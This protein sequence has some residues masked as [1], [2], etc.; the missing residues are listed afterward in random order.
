MKA[1]QASH[2][3][4]FPITEAGQQLNML[5]TLLSDVASIGK[6]VD[7]GAVARNCTASGAGLTQASVGQE[8][9][10]VIQAVNHYDMKCNRGGD[11]FEVDALGDPSIKFLVTDNA[12]GTYTVVYTSVKKC[13]FQISIRLRGVQIKGSPF[14]KVVFATVYFNK[15]SLIL[16]DVLASRLAGMLPTDRR[17]LTH[18]GTCHD[19]TA[20][21][22]QYFWKLVKGK[23]KIVVVVRNTAGHVFGGFVEDVFTPIDK[24]T[25]DEMWI[26]G[27]VSNFVFT[28][29]GDSRAPTKLI[30]SDSGQVKGLFMGSMA[31]FLMG[32]KGCHDL[33]VESDKDDRFYCSPTVYTAAAPGY[34]DVK[35]NDTLLAGSREWEPKII[36]VWTCA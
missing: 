25:E 32:K 17:T 16:T 31:A 35:V 12:N 36:E 10:F 20:F 6:V 28:L 27:H 24:K 23:G 26:S 29:G 3:S 13:D 14:T 21:T 19:K 22:P 4:L 30:K 8:A 18:L 2:L 1:L 15:P 5:R 33:R 34:P 9:S 11:I 7:S